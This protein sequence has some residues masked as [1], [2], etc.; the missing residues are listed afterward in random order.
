[1]VSIIFRWLTLFVL[2][3][4]TNGIYRSPSSAHY[5]PT[6]FG[7]ARNE[8]P[9]LGDYEGHYCLVAGE[10]CSELFP[11]QARPCLVAERCDPDG[12][13]VMLA[14]RIEREPSNNRMQRTH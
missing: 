8:R 12:E 5:H 10:L 14:H 2:V 13:L 6:G 4:W 1:M 3:T 7:E 11:K 9:R